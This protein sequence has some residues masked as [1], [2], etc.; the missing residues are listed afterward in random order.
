MVIPLVVFF[1]GYPG[2]LASSAFPDLS[3]PFLQI[4][5]FYQDVAAFGCKPKISQV[6]H[7][8]HGR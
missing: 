3:H 8:H 6:E 7:H 2:M 5:Y 4:I 1:W